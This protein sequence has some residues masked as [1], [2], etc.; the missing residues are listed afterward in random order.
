MKQCSAPREPLVDGVRKFEVLAAREDVEAVFSTLVGNGLKVRQE[1]RN[2][3]NLVDDGTCT[4]P[5]QHASW[6]GF[7]KFS[8]IRG[9]QVEVGPARKRLAAKRGLARLARS[10]HGHEWVTLE[11]IDQ[12]R[13]DL[14]LD[15]SLESTM[16]SCNL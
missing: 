7:G 6:I 8:L 15:H 14:S 4:E 3:S 1:A 13:D 5:S 9:F 16:V 10:R 12:A 11:E 2:T